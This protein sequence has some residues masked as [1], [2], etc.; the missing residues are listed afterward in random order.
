MLSRISAGLI[1]YARF[2]LGRTAQAQTQTLAEVLAI[3]IFRDKRGAK[4]IQPEQRSLTER[5]DIEDVLNVENGC[6]SWTKVA[7]DTD[8][9]FHPQS[10]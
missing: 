4:A 2:G 9:F 8:E 10:R 6:R 1:R 5:I 7:G 3:G